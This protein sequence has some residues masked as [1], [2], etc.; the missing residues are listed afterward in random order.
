[1]SQLQ[2]QNYCNP[3]NVLS[4]IRRKCTTINYGAFE[5]SRYMSSQASINYRYR[6]IL[7][8]VTLVNLKR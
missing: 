4:N 7:H 5:I 6:A 1:M 8:I 2:M 3:Y